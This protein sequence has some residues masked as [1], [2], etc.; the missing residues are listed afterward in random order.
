MLSVGAALGGLGGA[1][2]LDT[3]Q[4]WRIMI[5]LGAVLPMFPIVLILFPFFPESP[6]WLVMMGE[7]ERALDALEQ[8]AVDRPSAE[9]TLSEIE[10]ELRAEQRALSGHGGYFAALSSQCK[11]LLCPIA[12][13]RLRIWAALGTLVAAFLSGAIAVL[14]YLPLVLREDLTR[15]RAVMVASAITT[16][17]AI[18]AVIGIKLPDLCGRRP[19]LLVGYCL[20]IVMFAQLSLAMSPWQPFG[21]GVTRGLWMAAWLFFG[22]AAFQ[23]S[24]SPVTLFYCG[25]ILPSELRAIGMGVGNT[26][27]RVVAFCITYSLPVLLQTS[28]WGTYLGFG[29]VN[30]IIVLFVYLYVVETRGMDLEKIGSLYSDDTTNIKVKSKV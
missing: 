30:A 4:D 21:A 19:V 20:I 18:V 1:L 24:V 5:L 13:Q 15:R 14:I 28:S 25:E 2:L 11:E 29:C 6:R 22:A 12:S 16:T 3:W 9:K 10:E 26:L 17:V 23:L 7:R 27:A 8:L